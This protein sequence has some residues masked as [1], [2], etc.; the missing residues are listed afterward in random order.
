MFARSGSKE[1]S[2]PR[3][4]TPPTPSY[5]SNEQFGTHAAFDCPRDVLLW[6]LA[7]C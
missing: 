1:R 5:M 4:V 3:K 6:W 7:G 2:S